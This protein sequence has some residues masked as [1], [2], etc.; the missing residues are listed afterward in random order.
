MSICGLEFGTS[1]ATLGTIAGR[2]PVLTVL[3]AGQ[4]TIPR[5]IFYEV[6]ARSPAR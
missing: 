2:E 3:E 5:A 6:C 4:T 1:N